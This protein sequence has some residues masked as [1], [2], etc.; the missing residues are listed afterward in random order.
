[1]GKPVLYI[2]PTCATS[3]RVVKHL[4]SRGLLS[5][6]ELASTSEPWGAL[7]AGAWSVP[8]LVVDGVPA[9]TDPVEPGELEAMLLGEWKPPERVDPVEAVLEAVLHSAYASAVAVAHASLLPAL[10]R[11]LASAALRAPLSGADVDA[12]LAELRGAADSLWG[13]WSDKLV[14]ALGI[15]FVREMWWASRGQ[16]SRE[17]LRDTARP[18]VL[19]AWLLA[20]ASVGRTGLPGRPLPDP[21]LLRSMS[22]FVSR[23]AAGLLNRVRREQEEILGDEG[24]WRL[25]E[26]HGLS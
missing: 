22:N 6:V 25:L 24:Y 5:R 11:G 2:H 18:H 3:Y 26:E 20:K 15:S 16:L 12:V 23:A 9:A 14:R 17:E 1:M 13:V 19:G 8:W 21:Q 10:D 4:A 7:R